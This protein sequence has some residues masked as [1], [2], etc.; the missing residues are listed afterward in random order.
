[1]Q[2]TLRNNVADPEKGSG[3]DGQSQGYSALAEAMISSPNNSSLIFRRFDQVNVRNLL[4]LESEIA[5]LGTKLGKLE[6]E[7]G[8]HPLFIEGLQ[9]WGAIKKH[10]DRDGDTVLKQRARDI[11][12]VT[13][14]LEGKMAKYCTHISHIYTNN[15][16]PPANC[17]WQMRPSSAHLRFSNSRPQSQKRLTH[18]AKSSMEAHANPLQVQHRPSLRC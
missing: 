16:P 4:I 8:K 15:S 13:G 7:G 9:D 11:V 6:R 2:P 1:M 5:E 10:A 14:E 18:S 12:N 17:E 3:N